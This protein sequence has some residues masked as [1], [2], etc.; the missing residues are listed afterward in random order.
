ML[1]KIPFLLF[2]LMAGL[3]WAQP[4]YGVD[5][6]AQSQ[7]VNRGAVYDENI[8]LWPDAWVSYKGF[9]AV[10]FAN[11][12]TSD[13]VVNEA[14]LFLSWNTTT[15]VVTDT[16]GVSVLTFPG[17]GLSPTVELS[18]AV[19]GAPLSW[20][21]L[22]SAI[23]VD[24]MDAPGG[25][26]GTVGA[27]MAH[28]AKGIGLSLRSWVGLV[29]SKEAEYLYGVAY[30]GWSDISWSLGVSKTWGALTATLYINATRRA[31][32]ISSDRGVSWAGMNIGYVL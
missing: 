5:F 2:I 8:V 25:V 27:A 24:V 4:M 1:G 16:V 7:Y 10:A 14:D 26:Y 18:L 29:N 11:A 17:T 3:S 28:E 12:S 22:S 19:A 30:T 13:M 9:T 6:G 15:G 21:S 20:L 32:E 23:R 31:W